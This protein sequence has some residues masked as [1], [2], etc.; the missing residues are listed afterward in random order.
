MCDLTLIRGIHV[1]SVSVKRLLLV[2]DMSHTHLQLWGGGRSHSMCVN[3]SHAAAPRPTKPAAIWISLNWFERF[4]CDLEQLKALKTPR[5]TRPQQAGF[6][7][8]RTIV[9]NNNFSD[10]PSNFFFQQHL[11]TNLAIY[12]FIWQTFDK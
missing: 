4:I 9:A 11:A 3:H 5:K 7:Q 8:D 2:S 12:R 1:C 6:Q 10:Y